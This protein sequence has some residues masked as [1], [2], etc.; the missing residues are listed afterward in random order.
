MKVCE[1][2][3]SLQG[4]SS[5]AGLPCTFVRL[6]GCN[7]RCVYC[8]TQY[9][10][11]EGEEMSVDEIRERV[12]SAGVGL[13]EITGGEPLLQKDT[14][15]L[16]SGLLEEGHTV[17]LET[18]GSV[19]I[20]GIDRRAVVILDV[21]T[22]GSG[23]GGKTDLANFDLVKPTDEIKF[24]LCGRADYEWAKES[25]VKHGLTEKARILFS[26][27]VGMLAP[28]DLA[29]WIIDDRLNVRLNVQIHK[30]IFGPDERGV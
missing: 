12:K 1:I 6:S 25:L 28:S 30:Y 16:V 10:Y 18:N 21:K 9:S 5:Y 14:P 15:G 26:A 11:E 2:F 24:V 23:M 4:E 3:T 13:V 29:R 17:L 7:L 8:D 19:S 20:G 27:A 22:P